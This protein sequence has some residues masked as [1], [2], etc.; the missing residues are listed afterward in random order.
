MTASHRRRRMG[1][2]SSYA[3]GFLANT[4]V[5]WHEAERC[6]WQKR[7]DKLG[8]R[9][10]VLSV[11]RISHNVPAF[12]TPREPGEARRRGVRRPSRCANLSRACGGKAVKPPPRE[13]ALLCEVRPC[14]VLMQY[15]RIA[16]LAMSPYSASGARS[17]C[18][19]MPPG[20]K[21]TYERS[22]M[23][24]GDLSFPEQY[25]AP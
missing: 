15:C 19:R 12:T 5:V 4:S 23:L 1:R 25:T 20:R 2:S 24:L 21:P 8:K 9:E 17:I 3:S 22:P 13:I 6:T 18:P 7:S 10:T 14:D 16:T 11:G